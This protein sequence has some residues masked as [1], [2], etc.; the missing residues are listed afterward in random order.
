M[1]QG[2]LVEVTPGVAFIPTFGNISAVS[3]TAGLVMFD[4]GHSLVAATAREQLRGWSTERVDVV[5]FTHGHLDHVLGIAEFEEEAR[6]AGWQP[7]RVIAH[8]AVPRRF[9]RYRATAGYNAA[10]NERQFQAPGIG[11]PVDY[12]YPMRRTAT[13]FASRSAARSLSCIMPWA[14]PTTTRGPGCHHAVSSSAAT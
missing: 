4:T 7:P 10:V 8:E 1:M 13:S 9:D 5:V 12:R 14:R 3:T 2:G 11:W 6:V